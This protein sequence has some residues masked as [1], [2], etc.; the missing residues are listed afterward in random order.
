MWY[1]TEHVRVGDFMIRCLYFILWTV[2][3]TRRSAGEGGR[4]LCYVINPSS[5]LIGAKGVANIQLT[6]LYARWAYVKNVGI[7]L[8][9][10]FYTREAMVCESIV[11]ASVLILAPTNGKSENSDLIQIP[12]QPRHVTRKTLWPSHPIESPLL[13]FRPRRT[14]SHK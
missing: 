5:V 2:L 9:R 1:V 8:L 10:T 7:Y 3:F 12:S 4:M 13:H 6:P 11:S 14:R